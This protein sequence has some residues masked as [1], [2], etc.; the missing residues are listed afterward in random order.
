[1]RVTS[2]LSALVVITLF[3]SALIGESPVG[4]GA[5]SQLY[6][7]TFWA[8]SSGSL[9]SATQTNSVAAP[10]Q[11]FSTMGFSNPNYVFRDWNTQPNGGG[12]SYPD[13][14]TYPF[15][16]DLTLFAQWVQVFH[17][18][19]FFSNTTKVDTLTQS[20]TG[21]SPTTLTS[22]AQLGFS[23]VNYTF[24][25]WNSR[26][27]GSGNSYSDQAVYSFVSDLSLYAQWT[28]DSETLTFSPNSGTGGVSQLV[29]PYGSSVTIPSGGGSLTRANY[30]F[31]G[32]N[33]KSDGSGTQLPP[34]SSILMPT[35]E[36]LFAQWAPDSD[37]L[38]FS[39]NSGTG[40]VAPIVATYGNSVALPTGNSLSRSGY[41]FS[42][43]NTQADGSGTE[44]SPGS[45]LQVSGAETLYATWSRG[46]YVVTYETSSGQGSIAPVSVPAGGAI[47]L[48]S[49]PK[50]RNRGYSFVG[51]FTAPSG[52]QLVGKSG[53]SFVPTG[54]ITLYEHW[55]ALPKLRLR[56]AD[57][58]GTG[59]VKTRTV[60]QGLQLVIPG[61]S[62]LHRV[63]F[64][65]RGWS[66]SARASQPNE[67][68]GAKVLLTHSITLFALW[69]RD[70]RAS[71]P[72]VLLGSVGEF[73]PNSST[74]TPAMIRFIATLALGIDHHN[75]TVVTIYGYATTKDSSRGALQLSLRRALVVKA[76][77]E[78][79]LTALNDVGVRLHAS[80]EARLSSSVLASFRNV[81][82]FAN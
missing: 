67:R 9:A 35:T 4:A 19:T 10:L 43:W 70:P 29:A 13:Q 16:S 64:T 42:G 72:Q 71:A 33:T 6:S 52:G 80:G 36:T 41:T 44:Y 3:S 62:G 21:N 66:T 20:E 18:V 8:N 81:E 12:T 60:R 25:S 55:T 61:G 63:G 5:V 56:F 77:L 76:Q 22:I 50:G 38:S 26:A 51:W 68:I 40:S 69:R 49:P 15:T 34:G 73:A 1:M 82:V 59:V 32:W 57:N 48:Q 24:G 7:V 2:W 31:T 17:A 27:D 37:T 53:S 54:A 47:T 79:D 45:V 65:F 14:S 23:K 75:R 39:S 58:G 78:R 46:S 11:A 74:L 30:T 28:P